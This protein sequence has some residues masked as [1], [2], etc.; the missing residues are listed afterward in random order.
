M[1]QKSGARILLVLGFLAAFVGYDAWIVSHAIF[2]PNTTRA[3][4]H[5]LLEAPAVRKGLADQI[6]NELDQKIPAA[7]RDPPRRPP[8]PPRSAT[9]ASR[10]HSPTPLPRSTPRFCPKTRP[11]GSPSTG[12]RS[13][14]H[15]TTRSHRVIR[16]SRRNCARSRPSPCTSTRTTCRGCTTRVRPQIP[17]RRSQSSPR[18]SSSP[19]RSSCSTTGAPSDESGAAPRS[20]RSLPYL[21][22]SR[23]R[24]C[25]RHASGNAPQI[26]SALLRVYGDRVLPSAIALIVVGLVIA[27]CAIVWPRHPARDAHDAAHT[28]RRYTGPEPPRPRTAPDQPSI[29]EKMYL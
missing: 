20:W 1:A 17:S 26:A 16:S 28:A 4:A 24:S 7:R 12:T 21:C 18:S 6:T 27:L 15:C 8:S 13:R 3:A 25:S 14:T 19:R 29:T 23:C 11:R 2:D 5:A 10:V 22:S 9:H